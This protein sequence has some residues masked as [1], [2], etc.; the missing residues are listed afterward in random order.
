[1]II[2]AVDAEKVWQNPT[3]THEKKKI[4]KLGTE[5]TFF[6]LIKNIYKNPTA[7]I[8]LRGEKLGVESIPLDFWE[9]WESLQ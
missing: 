2:Y 4:S 3:P 6:N 8:I 5:E 7:N 1:M 9:T